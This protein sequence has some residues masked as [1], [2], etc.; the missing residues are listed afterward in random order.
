MKEIKNVRKLLENP[1]FNTKV[2][3]FFS[4]KSYGS[5]Y[6]PYESNATYSNLNPLT[7]KGYVTEVSAE[8]LVWKQ[9]GLH[10]MGAKEILCEDKYKAAFEKCNKVEMDDIEYQVFREGTGSRTIIQKRPGNL[11][12]VVVTRK[13]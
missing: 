9:Y 1:E 5:D 6:D 8:A 12:R 2:N 3:L 10:Q 13:G 11:M 7:I 4:S